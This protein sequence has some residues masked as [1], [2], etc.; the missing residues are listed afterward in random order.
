MTVL[1]VGVEHVKKTYYAKLHLS[2]DTKKHKP[3]DVERLAGLFYPE[4]PVRR[5]MFIFLLK[6]AARE[7]FAV[8]DWFLTVC[9]FVEEYEGVDLSDVREY[10]IDQRGYMS[11]TKLNNESQ[12]RADEILKE[13]RRGDGYSF[14]NY[15][16]IYNRVVKD[17]RVAGLLYKKDDVYKYSREFKKI[18]KAMIEALED[19]EESG[20]EE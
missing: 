5:S 16:K 6:K 18:L 13:Q 17:M 8:E 14:Y 4:H 15:V 20:G 10:Y 7:G 11:T 9:E 12:A 3:D 2:E 1:D 19:F